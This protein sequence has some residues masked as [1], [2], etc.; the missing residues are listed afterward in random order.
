[1]LPGAVGAAA[2]A[3]SLYASAYCKFLSFTSIDGGGGGGEP[4]ALYLGIWYYQGLSVVQSDIQG[5]SVVENCYNYPAGTTVDAPWGSA[6]AFSA[7]ALVVGGVVTFWALLVWCFPPSERTCRWGA[8]LFLLCCP[9][10]GLSL[11]LLGSDACRDDGLATALL[12]GRSDSDAPGATALPSS[13]SMASGAGCAIAATVLW[14]LAAIAAWRV[15]PPARAPLTVQTQTVTYTKTVGAD[16][17][18]MVSEVVVKGE[19]VAVGGGGGTEK[20][21]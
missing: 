4:V 17:A 3:A 15:D 10:Q 19:P 6:R 20:A 12:E 16:G 13:C 18:E 5:T 9:L 11:L 1:M 7:M 2:F 21:V 14:V 8:A